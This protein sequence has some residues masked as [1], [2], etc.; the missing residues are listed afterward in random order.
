M[1][2]SEP[3]YFFL[4]KFTAKPKTKESI[5]VAKNKR[6]EIVFLSPQLPI[7]SSGL[8][9]SCSVTIYV[10]QQQQQQKRWLIPKS[11]LVWMSGSS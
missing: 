8:S 11:L 2:K 6:I 10:K 3:G 7:Y 9:R 4:T 5:R 1:R